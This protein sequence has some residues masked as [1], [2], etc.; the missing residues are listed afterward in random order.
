MFWLQAKLA[1]ISS[2]R[3]HGGGQSSNNQIVHKTNGE[4]ETN[5]PVL[6]SRAEKP[7][8]QSKLYS[9]LLAKYGESLEAKLASRTNE[10]NSLERQDSGK[11]VQQSIEIAIREMEAQQR[12]ESY[13][14][15]G[16][17]V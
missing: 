17:K 12:L 8:T 14:K 13:D 10:D 11:I 1:F 16:R 5:L 2:H 7:F 9:T 4:D 6:P 15:G 3:A